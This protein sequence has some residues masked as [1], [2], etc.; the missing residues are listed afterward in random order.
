MKLNS[1]YLTSIHFTQQGS[2]INNSCITFLVGIKTINWD[3]YI[4]FRPAANF[5]GFGMGGWWRNE[6]E[7]QHAH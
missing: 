3:V 1:L 6:R 4:R 7:E 2:R 5:E